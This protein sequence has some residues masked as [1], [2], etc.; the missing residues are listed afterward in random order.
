MAIM[1]KTK[2]VEMGAKE[3][4]VREAAENE[5]QALF[6]MVYHEHRHSMTTDLYRLEAELVIAG[7]RIETAWGKYLH[8]PDGRVIVLDDW[9][10]VD[11]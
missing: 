6:R 3:S 4:A 10:E 5:Y 2:E 7:Y 1:T 9:N 11:N 8:T